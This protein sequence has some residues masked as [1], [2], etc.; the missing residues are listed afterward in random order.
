MAGGARAGKETESKAADASAGDNQAASQ[1]KE[2]AETNTSSS[3]SVAQIPATVEQAEQKPRA[4]VGAK[5]NSSPA[6]PVGQD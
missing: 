5:D 1:K 4:D 6:P 2:K 3:P